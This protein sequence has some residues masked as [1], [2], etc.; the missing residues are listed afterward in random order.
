MALRKYRWS[1]VYESS[2]EELHDLL[3]AM[4]IK[5]T[6]ATS[7]VAGETHQHMT[8]KPTTLWCVEGSLTVQTEDS[9]VSLQPGDALHI[10]ASIRYVVTSG[11]T[12]YTYYDSAPPAKTIN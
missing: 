2:E 4:N 1:K 3:E 10:P 11:L 6:V 5:A 12:G 7:E 9:R 8:D